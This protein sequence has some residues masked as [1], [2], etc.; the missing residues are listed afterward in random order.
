MIGDPNPAVTLI[1]QGGTTLLDGDTFV[2]DDGGRRLT[3][4]FDSVND[5]NIIQGNVKVSFDPADSEPAAV[6]DSIRDAI[7]R[8]FAAGLLKITAASGDSLDRAKSSGGR[9]ELFGEAVV[10]NPSSGRFIKLDLVAEETYLGRETAK[11]QPVVNHDTESS[12][13]LNFADELARHRAELC[14][15]GF[16]YDR[17]DRENR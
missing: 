5:G 12:V 17:G 11:Q 15:W 13:D 6:A 10:V 4:E 3:F 8:Q 2:L 16:R 7:N 1:A 9:V 14:E